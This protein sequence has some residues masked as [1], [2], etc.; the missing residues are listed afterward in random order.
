MDNRKIGIFDSGVGGLTVL[1]EIIEE[2][3]NENIIYI[4]DTKRFPY[5][6]KSKENI[7]QISKQIVNYLILQ[8]V[9]LIVIACGTA[10]SQAL[11]ELRK[12]YKIP[13]VGIIEPTIENCIN[14]NTKSVGIIAT[15]GTI[16]SNQWEKQI[17]QK[18]NNVQVISIETPLLASMAEEGWT[19]NDVAKAAIKEYMKKF[20]NSN[21]EKLILGCTHYPLFE[22]LIKQ[23]LGNK[24]ETI[25][26]GKQMAKYLKKYLEENKMFS[27]L[28]KDIS[29]CLQAQ[30]NITLTDT[31][32]NFINIAEKLLNK[33]IKINKVE[34]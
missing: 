8:D 21:I 6:N 32:C 10:T 25:N 7:V 5:G 33:R 28:Q 30:Y 2:L 16:R 9:K 22:E 26:T 12:I 15:K 24:V 23:E 3:P 19:N 17:K 14:D 27:N 4:G 29:S 11:E 1:S 31:E 18:N 34:L 13:I 20:R